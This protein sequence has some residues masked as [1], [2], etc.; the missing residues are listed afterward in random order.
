MLPVL[1]GWFCLYYC[2]CHLHIRRP[3]RVSYGSGLLFLDSW[4]VV[5]KWLSTECSAAIG[6]HPPVVRW[7]PRVPAAHHLPQVRA[8][9][10]RRP[11]AGMTTACMPLVSK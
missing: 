6:R 7:R 2:R 3:Q 4:L 5:E 11:H 8:P 9:S 10:D 1:V